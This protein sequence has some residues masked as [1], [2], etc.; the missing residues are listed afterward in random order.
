M[1]TIRCSFRVQI[2]PEHVMEAVLQHATIVVQETNGKLVVEPYFW[3]Y[4]LIMMKVRFFL[5]F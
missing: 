2:V 3:H 4:L 1:M 5:I